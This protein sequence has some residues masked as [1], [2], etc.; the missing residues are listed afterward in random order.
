MAPADIQSQ[1][2]EVIVNLKAAL[3]ERDNRISDLEK[4]IKAKEYYVPPTPRGLGTPQTTLDI[5]EDMAQ[6]LREKIARIKELEEENAEYRRKEAYN[7]PSSDE[8]DDIQSDDTAIVLAE[9][10][11]MANNA[12]THAQDE[13]TNLG[14]EVE[15][16]QG[17]LAQREEEITALIEENEEIVNEGPYERSERLNVLS[18]IIAGIAPEPTI[19]IIN[20]HTCIICLDKTD[21]PFIRTNKCHFDHGVCFNCFATLMNGS[22]KAQ[23]PICMTRWEE[24]NLLIE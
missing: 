20:D 13:I 19:D 1:L 18:K 22:S 8:S 12:L 14:H 15:R 2:K 23:C 21:G 3:T 16:L 6:S 24:G 4:E 9:E 10:L 17:L 11:T 5:M 7:E